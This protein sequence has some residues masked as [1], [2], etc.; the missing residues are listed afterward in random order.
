MTWGQGRA[1]LCHNC[2]IMCS[3]SCFVYVALAPRIWCSGHHTPTC[4]RAVSAPNRDQ[5]FGTRLWSKGQMGGV[6]CSHREHPASPTDGHF[7]TGAVGISREKEWPRIRHRPQ[8]RASLAP[9]MGNMYRIYPDSYRLST[10]SCLLRTESWGKNTHLR[11]E[12][13]NLQASK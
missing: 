13:V 12:P 6:Q 5:I 9:A 10:G 3:A 8:S 2:S 11:C 4:D 7:V 1:T